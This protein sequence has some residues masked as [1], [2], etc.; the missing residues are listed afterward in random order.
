VPLILH[1]SEDP[2]PSGTP[3]IHA[4][5]SKVFHSKSLRPDLS[6]LEVLGDSLW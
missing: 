5:I 1:V 3:S 6:V 4:G 2:D